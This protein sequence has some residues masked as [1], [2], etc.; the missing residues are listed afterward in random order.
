MKVNRTKVASTPDNMTVPLDVAIGVFE[1]LTET[2]PALVEETTEPYLSRTF[3]N[4]SIVTSSDALIYIIPSK[5]V[6]PEERIYEIVCRSL[7]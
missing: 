7:L 2:V 6:S 5:N 3:N 4:A 1:R